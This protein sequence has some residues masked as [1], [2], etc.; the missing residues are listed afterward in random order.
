MSSDSLAQLSMLTKPG[1]TA[2]PVASITRSAL[3]A[4]APTA[5]IR[6]S[7]MAT[8]ATTG[9]LPEPSKTVPPRMSRS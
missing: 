9:G 8:S 6:S 5:T 3:P 1:A 4:V 2:R 7:R